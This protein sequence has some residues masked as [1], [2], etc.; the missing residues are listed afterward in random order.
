MKNNNAQSGVAEEQ[1]SNSTSETAIDVIN[2]IYNNVIPQGRNTINSVEF[3]VGPL[4]RVPVIFFPEERTG[5]HFFE[6]R[7]LQSDDS[8]IPED[9]AEPLTLEEL[10]ELRTTLREVTRDF[11][12]TNDDEVAGTRISIIS[13]SQLFG[14]DISPDL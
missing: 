10:Q 12:V 4:G 11:S 8:L 5:Y 1:N 9:A 3:C 14:R 13:I 7:V 6:N 2:D